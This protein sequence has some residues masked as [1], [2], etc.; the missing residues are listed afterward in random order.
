MPSSFPRGLP[1][2]ITHD[3]IS[4]RAHLLVQAMCTF[5]AISVHA[6]VLTAKWPHAQGPSPTCCSTPSMQHGQHFSPGRQQVHSQPI[7]TSSV[8]QT[9]TTRSHQDMKPTLD[10]PCM[11]RFLLAQESE[12]SPSK[13]SQHYSTA[14][15]VAHPLPSVLASPAH[16]TA[17]NVWA[18]CTRSPRNR[19]SRQ[20]LGPLVHNQ[21]TRQTRTF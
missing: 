17:L 9:V 4:P 10:S 14:A 6:L 19:P 7:G 5:L 21:H 12:L 15:H 20:P 13:H 3:S 2:S 1:S 8:H 11:T 18:N 16:H